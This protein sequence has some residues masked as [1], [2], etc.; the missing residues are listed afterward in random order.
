ME[1]LVSLVVFWG[2]LVGVGILFDWSRKYA[3]KKKTDKIISVKNYIRRDLKNIEGGDILVKQAC[4]AVSQNPE[5]YLEITERNGAN[6]AT[7]VAITE[8]AKAYAGALEWRYPITTQEQKEK[9]TNFVT[10][11]FNARSM[12]RSHVE[13]S[14]NLDLDVDD[15]YLLIFSRLPKEAKAIYE[16]LDDIAF[17]KSI[18]EMKKI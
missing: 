17:Y 9:L 3:E 12:I 5:K 14:M 11:L 16:K 4:Y 15:Q 18:E 2:L 6:G 1:T 8:G 10:A 13:Y 7:A